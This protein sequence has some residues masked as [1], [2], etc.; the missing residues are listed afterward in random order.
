MDMECWRKFI[1]NL[2]SVLTISVDD[3]FSTVHLVLYLATF[4]KYQKGLDRRRDYLLL[5][6]F[7]SF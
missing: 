2:I 7:G 5:F 3:L 1:R 4:I 6:I